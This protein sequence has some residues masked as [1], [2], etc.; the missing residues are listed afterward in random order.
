MFALCDYKQSHEQENRYMWNS[1]VKPKQTEKWSDGVG[2]AI[3]Q[4]YL[5]AYS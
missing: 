3:M 1:V 2:I 4:N 5:F